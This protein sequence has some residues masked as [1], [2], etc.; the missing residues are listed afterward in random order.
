MKYY[1]LDI[2]NDLPQN[3]GRY[4]QETGNA[5]EKINFHSFD[6]E[7]FYG[8]VETFGTLRN[9]PRRIQIEKLDPSARNKD[10]IDGVTIIFCTKS[11]LPWQKK[12][13]GWYRNAII[14]RRQQQYSFSESGKEVQY[15]YFFKAM[16]TDA[17]LLPEINR[18]FL[19]PQKR[20]TANNNFG[21]GRSNLWYAEDAESFIRRVKN[22]I[23]CFESIPLD[24]QEHSD[25][26]EGER[27]LFL[28]NS[29]SR[30]RQAREEC[31]RSKG[32]VC[33][34]CKKKVAEIYGEDFRQVIE[35]HH[36]QP[37]SERNG[38]YNINP[39]QDLIPV[40]PTCHRVLHTKKESGQY[41]TVE[42]LQAKFNART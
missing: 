6:N 7:F 38:I 18:E 30:S 5:F 8:F 33:T 26:Q 3:G 12:I 9:T 41:P 15:P 10:Y 29:S 25:F 23:D 21:F 14:Y 28:V 1:D 36:L 27:R 19:V 24:E 34:I 40:C 16:Q 42:E 2:T 13:V 35:V 11:T 32:Y 20:K 22:Y 4:V 37:I 39:V 31:L 17:V